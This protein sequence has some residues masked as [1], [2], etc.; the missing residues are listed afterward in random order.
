VRDREYAPVPTDRQTWSVLPQGG[1]PSVVT[2]K[3]F[4]AATDKPMD[5]EVLMNR[6]LVTVQPK[7]LA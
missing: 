6:Y 4:G 3:S 7:G 5:T 1:V 2:G